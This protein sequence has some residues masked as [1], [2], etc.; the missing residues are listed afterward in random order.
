MTTVVIRIE[1]GLCVLTMDGHATGSETVCAACS[2]VVYALAG[3]L[4]NAGA[5]IEDVQESTLES[6]MARLVCRGDACVETAYRM[7]GIGLAQ[8]AQQ[9]PELVRVDLSI[10]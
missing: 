1:D 10:G 5:H 2:A 7:A 8:I 6:G 4:A 3:Y 9:Y